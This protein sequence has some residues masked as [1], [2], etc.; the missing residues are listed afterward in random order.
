MIPC[1]RYTLITPASLHRESRYF[2][3]YT[4]L[5]VTLIF[6]LPLANQ[7]A[8]RKTSGSVEPPQCIEPPSAKCA[9]VALQS[10]KTQLL[11]IQDFHYIFHSSC[12][13]V[14]LHWHWIRF[15]DIY[16]FFLIMNWQKICANATFK[17][18]NETLKPR[19][20]QP[21]GTWG[22]KI[23]FTLVSHRVPDLWH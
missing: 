12:H 19:T 4:Q 7:L 15:Q 16:I 13:K 17:A 14:P 22:E 21:K 20:A 9:Y 10:K 6:Q 11:C 2:L 8:A 5:H 3:H 1:A 23:V 18:Q